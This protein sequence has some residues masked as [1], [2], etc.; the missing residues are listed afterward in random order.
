MQFAMTVGTQHIAFLDF[1]LDAL[2]GPRVFDHTCDAD[3]LCLWI[4]MVEI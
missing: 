3:F 4:T 2:N 1:G